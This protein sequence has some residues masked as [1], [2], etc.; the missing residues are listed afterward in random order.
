MNLKEID[1]LL[2]EQDE[3]CDGLLLDDED[4]FDKEPFLL[5]MIEEDDYEVAGENRDTLLVERDTNILNSIKKSMSSKHESVD[6]FSEHA[7]GTPLYM[8]PEVWTSKQYSKAADVWAI[9]II[10]HEIATLKHPFHSMT[11][12]ELKRRVC[13]EQ[14]SK[15]KNSLLSEELESLIHK[16]LSKDPAQRPSLEEII[17]EDNF[18]KRAKAIVN[19]PLRLN[20]ERQLQQ[21]QALKVDKLRLTPYSRKLFKKELQLAKQKIQELEQQA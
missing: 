3:D 11:K 18:Q 8:A 6:F 12:E 17:L 4:P 21:I 1:L 9:G 15:Q 20:K 13:T 14:L 10:L 2:D 19:L 5:D 16:M 7:V